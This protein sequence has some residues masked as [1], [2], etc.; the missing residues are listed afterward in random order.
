MYASTLAA[1]DILRV[2]AGFFLE[3]ALFTEAFLAGALFAVGFWFVVFL[4]GMW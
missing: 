2:T 1:V 4:V 3:P